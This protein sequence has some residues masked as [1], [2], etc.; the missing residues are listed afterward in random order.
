M[1]KYLD[2]AVVSYLWSKLKNIQKTNL[3]Y[4]SK[5]TQQW[6]STPFLMSEAN[7]LYIYDDYKKIIDDYGNE[8]FIPGLK[9][10]D[11]KAYLIDLPFLNNMTCY[12]FT[13]QFG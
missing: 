1:T 2:P 10:G 12:K 4:Q 3:T 5:S 6:N 13:R 8:V 9:V 11:G 7:V